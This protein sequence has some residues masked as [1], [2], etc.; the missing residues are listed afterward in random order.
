MATLML[1]IGGLLLGKK[2]AATAKAKAEFARVQQEHAEAETQHARELQAAAEQRDRIHHREVLIQ[3]I[4]RAR[5]LPHQGGWRKSIESR[6]VEATQLG[7][8]DNSLRTQAI[9]SL[10][11]P[12]AREVKNLPYPA[13]NLVFDPQGRRLY[14]CGFEDRVIR[15]WDSQLDETRTLT[16]KG[17]GPFAFRPDG[18]PWQLAQ[19]DKDGRTLVL[20]D[21]A[22]ETVLR[23]FTSPQ[24]DRPFFADFAITPSG[25]HAAALWQASKPRDGIDPPENA[26][27]TLIAVWKGATGVVVR[28]IDHPAPAVALALAPDG[29]MLAVGDTRG[30]IVVWTL[31]DGNPYATL[32]AGDNR[33]QCLGFGR[34]PRVSC[35]QKPDTLAWQLAVG[36]GGGIVT[37]FDLQNRRIRNIERGSSY[38][39]KSLAFRPDGAVLVSAGRGE[40]RLWDVATGRLVLSVSAGNFLP[41]LALSQDGRRL[42]VARWGMFGDTTGVRVYDLRGGRGLQSLLR[43]QT[44]LERLQF[45]H[46]GGL[47]AALSDDWRV[48]IWERSSGE[49]RWLFTMPP[50]LFADNAWMVFDPTARRLAFSGG[51]RATLWDLETGQLLQ[52]WRLPP[53]LQDH[54]AFLGPRHLSLTRR[55]R[56]QKG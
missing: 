36:D 48:G 17:D 34:E 9:A 33:I 32:S 55:S 2:I 54:L 19:V 30:N 23:R 4:Q 52:T 10:R 39:I 53:G 28:L 45:S 16:L 27:P 22:L 47:V 44:R 50:G 40:A 21:L 29:R 6:I 35:R 26:P 11:E 43:L 18:T 24:Q 41:A 37:L 1:G 51:D 13:S 20:H 14:S 38:D 8:D 12:D 31:P 7:G 56:N 15:V 5:I 49:L 25:S 42:A 3:E 46:D